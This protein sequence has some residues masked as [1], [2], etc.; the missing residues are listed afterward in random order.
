MNLRNVL[1]SWTFIALT[2]C[3]GSSEEKTA[4]TALVE[5]SPSPQVSS[6]PDLGLLVK[7]YEGNTKRAVLTEDNLELLTSAAM[8]A[9]RDVE[10]LKEMILATTHPVLISSLVESNESLA[11]PG[12][13]SMDVVQAPE[14]EARDDRLDLIADSDVIYLPVDSSEVEL[15]FSNC[16]LAQGLQL[17]EGDRLDGRLNITWGSVELVT[18]RGSWWFS[19]GSYYEYLESTFVSELQ[20]NQ[21]D[22]FFEKRCSGWCVY[23][24]Y[25]NFGEQFYYRSLSPFGVI[26]VDE[27]LPTDPSQSLR[28]RTDISTWD[29]DISSEGEGGDDLPVSSTPAYVDLQLYHPEFGFIDVMWRS[30][31]KGYILDEQGGA[32]ASYS[33]SPLDMMTSVEEPEWEPGTGDCDLEQN[34]EDSE[35]SWCSMW[36]YADADDLAT[37]RV[38]YDSNGNLVFTAPGIDE[39]LA[40]VNEYLVKFNS[41]TYTFDLPF[42]INR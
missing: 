13:G 28:S 39:E 18:Q 14:L 22:L 12:G 27:L 34:T 9:Y 42:D 23:K 29:E 26:A 19:T 3:G 20:L 31:V 38:G 11:C 30:M 7:P 4:E 17:E 36:R 24:S 33:A 16:I 37:S 35:I 21:E 25:L 10:L 5:A 6:S 1:L 40:D 15:E 2:A 41:E 8:L 32:L